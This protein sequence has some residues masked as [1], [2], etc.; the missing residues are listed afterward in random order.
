MKTNI[1]HNKKTKVL[2]ISYT[3]LRGMREIKLSYFAG[4]IDGEGCIRI[5]KSTYGLRKRKDVFCPTYHERLQI[6][7]TDEAAIKSLVK[8]FGGTYY[9]ER[10]YTK[11]NKPL[12]VFNVNDKK[13]FEI[14]KEVYPYLKIK[15]KQSK[16]IFKLRDSKNSPEA[17][18]RG[19]PKGRRMPEPVIKYREGLFQQCKKLNSG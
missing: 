1:I 2:Y 15:T 3:F 14:I 8:F 19:G 18:R 12:Y 13:A 17:R 9:K 7:M 5:A 10:S 11:I 6:R 4:L 16:L